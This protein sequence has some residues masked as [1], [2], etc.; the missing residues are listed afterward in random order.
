MSGEPQ[1]SAHYSGITCVPVV[2]TY[3]SPCFI[4]ADLKSSL[5]RHRASYQPD[6]TITAYYSDTKLCHINN[7]SQHNVCLLTL[8][9]A[10]NTCVFKV[11]A[12]TSVSVISVRNWIISTD[13]IVVNRKLGTMLTVC[14]FAISDLRY[15]LRTNLGGCTILGEQ[16]P[17]PPKCC[18]TLCRSLYKHTLC[19]H[20]VPLHRWCPGCAT[21]QNCWSATPIHTFVQ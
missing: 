3:C 2:I 8:R 5:G 10:M 12:V 14:K 1:L 13:S 6:I 15:S 21:V 7:F 11:G 16:P 17:H 4:E 19:A 9:L 18:C 20:A